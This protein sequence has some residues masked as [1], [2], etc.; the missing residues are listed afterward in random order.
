MTLH[1]LHTLIPLYLYHLGLS[2]AVLGFLVAFPSLFQT[3]MRVPAG[4]A[5]DRWG[6]KA[7]LLI[8]SGSMV[9]ASLLFL[10]RILALVVVAQ[11]FTGIS[12]CCFHPSAQ[13]YLTRLP[14]LPMGT[15]LGLYNSMSGLGSVIGP[16]T[17]GFAIGGL[18][19][20]GAFVVFTASAVACFTAVLLLPPAAQA[21]AARPTHSM[22]EG[23]AEMLRIKP[24]LLAAGG[25]YAAALPM[26]LVG[27]FLPVYLR[28]VGMTPENVGVITGM[29]GFSIMIASLVFAYLYNR[30]R[31][32]TVWLIGM[33]GTGAAVA[34]IPTFS[35]FWPLVMCTAVLGFSS[36]PLQILPTDMVISNTPADQ[37][38]VA[39]AIIGTMWGLSLFLTPLLFGVLAQVTSLEVCFFVAAVPLLAM[40]ML[41]GPLFKWAYGVGEAPATG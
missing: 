29:R 12:R 7:V 4:M 1:I 3:F 19:Y 26:A 37:R 24:V 22:L 2:P 28:Q 5:S 36:S 30:M 23:L 31:K 21:Q 9:L 25:R 34:L 27:S 6:E 10:P 33:L 40:G 38:G 18:G 16:V 13:S 14:G 17:A 11:A 41:T 15:R 35:T 8:S 32:P 20:D 39:I